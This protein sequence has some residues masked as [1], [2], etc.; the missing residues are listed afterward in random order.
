MLKSC[1]ETELVEFASVDLSGAGTSHGALMTSK[2]TKTGS[3]DSLDSSTADHHHHHGARSVA[4]SPFDPSKTD[5]DLA[6]P[7][8]TV[9]LRSPRG[10][11]DS[12]LRPHSLDD[13][14]LGPSTHRD[15]DKKTRQSCE[16]QQNDLFD[17][18]LKSEDSLGDFDRAGSIRRSTRRRPK[19]PM[20]EERERP[21]PVPQAPLVTQ[22]NPK[23]S[24]TPPESIG[25]TIK[26][27]RTMVEKNSPVLETDLLV[28]T[29]R[30]HLPNDQAEIGARRSVG[31]EASI[32]ADAA[33]KSSDSL[34]TR[35]IRQQYLTV[36]DAAK[37]NGEQ[38]QPI[39]SSSC[40]I[41]N[42]QNS[43]SLTAGVLTINESVVLAK[44]SSDELNDIVDLIND[45][46]Q[47]GKDIEKKLAQQPQE[48]ASIALK[49]RGEGD[50][51]PHK[52]TD[53]HDKQATEADSDA[54]L[55]H[56]RQRG[57]SG[58]NSW[59][60]SVDVSPS[61]S[62]SSSSSSDDL[63][64]R[65]AK[66]KSSS[67][68]SFGPPSV[69]EVNSRT[70]TRS[71]ALSDVVPAVPPPSGDAD[72]A[73][74]LS[75]EQKARHGADMSPEMK[76][77]GVVF[78]EHSRQPAA[79]SNQSEQP[80]IHR[81]SVEEQQVEVRKENVSDDTQSDAIDAVGDADDVASV[82]A[83]T[84][85]ASRTENEKKVSVNTDGVKLRQE[86]HKNLSKCQTDITGGKWSTS[87]NDD[88]GYMTMSNRSS[89]QTASIASF[90][91]PE[92]ILNDWGRKGDL[93]STSE[94]KVHSVAVCRT[95]EGA[96]PDEGGSTDGGGVLETRE[97]P[98]DDQKT[99]TALFARSID[100]LV[101][102]GEMSLTGSSIDINT[103]ACADDASGHLDS[104]AAG[105]VV[106]G[107]LD[108]DWAD[109]GSEPCFDVSTPHRSTLSRE[110]RVPQDKILSPNAKTIKPKL[111]EITDRLS[112]PK[113]QT[114]TTTAPSVP[115]ST[116]HPSQ[117]TTSKAIS[118]SRQDPFVR[119]APSRVTMPAAVFSANKKK[120]AT[121]QT[122]LPPVPPQRT[123]SIRASAISD[124][125][126]KGV[127]TSQARRSV[128]PSQFGGVGSGGAKR[129]SSQSGHSGASSHTPD[130][131]PEEVSG[132]AAA[133]KSGDKHKSIFRKITQKNPI[134][135]AA[136]EEHVTGYQRPQKP[137]M[138]VS[139]SVR[140]NR[141]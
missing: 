99:G 8:P 54:A 89:T 110:I 128:E 42:Q 116:H 111:N 129:P 34:K 31:Q 136:N 92:K 45:L 133:A 130:S 131:L 81:V 108:T 140:S 5:S 121:D 60:R 107:D 104:E 4:T 101:V 7:Q 12:S 29:E 3:R 126:S 2:A 135:K 56:L 63:R 119:N 73:I 103:S 35:F 47:T 21:L 117:V 41:E 52:P 13:V 51:A 40:K 88:E 113:K 19:T 139:S 138:S 17:Y 28:R 38:S 76:R 43:Q 67:D 16:V 32:T 114:T 87:T 85:D 115:K 137:G 69:R 26:S 24:D 39:A 66:Y 18:L 50:G 120:A 78:D 59:R 11:P 20:G 44:G 134:R 70:S 105:E 53:T 90:D 10:T 86:T 132:P 65:I 74:Q 127:P 14:L 6:F 79:D 23:P 80:G 61:S 84:E 46:E 124:R 109:S 57:Q 112:R 97:G 95:N 9:V 15:A 91:D 64:K 106:S 25:S 48:N 68:A 33:S 125:L 72:V 36:N 58:G 141:S 122:E 1:S 77:W 98:T 37:S 100:S 55:I 123:T 71:A 94:A 82:H 102:K 118:S 30:R 96:A 49:E 75:S 22:N 62:A 27:W 83:T 93:E